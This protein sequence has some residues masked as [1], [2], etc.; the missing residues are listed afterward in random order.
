MVAFKQPNRSFAT[1]DL[2]FVEFS[3][4][5]AKLSDKWHMATN[6][7]RIL[8][9]ELG[10][11]FTGDGAFI[12]YEDADGGT[13]LQ[14]KYFSGKSTMVVEPHCPAGMLSPLSQFLV[15]VD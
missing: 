9:V 5:T 4:T 13:R 10:T 11:T 6:P 8:D 12:L 2:R 1:E 3:D 15:E 7:Q 14:W